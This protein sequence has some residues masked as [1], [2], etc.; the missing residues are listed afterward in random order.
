MQQ[1]RRA[2]KNKTLRTVAF[3]IF[4]WIAWWSAAVLGALTWPILRDNWIWTALFV[5]AGSIAYLLHKK[6][7]DEAPSC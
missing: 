5:T 1:Q 6:G 4:A 3:A 7:I 2:Q